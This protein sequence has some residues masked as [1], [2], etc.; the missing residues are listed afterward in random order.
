MH[1]VRLDLGIGLLGTAGQPLML[2][3]SLCS[4]HGV[5]GVE[6]ETDTGKRKGLEGLPRK[7]KAREA[8]KPA[9]TLHVA[10]AT[11]GA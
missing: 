5:G 7:R 2:P 6:R 10:A 8:V 4:L 9:R 3:W 11:R 1:A